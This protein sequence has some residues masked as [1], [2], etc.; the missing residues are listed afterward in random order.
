MSEAGP[1]GIIHIFNFKDDVTMNAGRISR[2]Q[3]LRLG[4]AALVVGA[5]SG[6]AGCGG[7][8]E[9]QDAPQLRFVN[10]TVDYSPADFWVDGLRGP[11]NVSSGGGF[12]GYGFVREGSRPVGVGPSGGAATVTVQ[13]SF[14]TGSFTTALALMGS[15]GNEELRFLDENHSAAP[16]GSVRL[17]VLNATSTNGYDVYVQSGAPSSSD[18]PLVAQGYNSLSDFTD[19]PSGW[20][21]VYITERNRPSVIFR[22]QEFNFPGRTV[23]SLVI[24]PVGASL[25]VVALQEQGVAARLTHHA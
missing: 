18:T 7:G 8:Q 5:G 23:G 4:T 17:R 1:C 20:R 10:A 12:T 6:L 14:A 19:L 21:R 24:V 25:A 13:R 3:A 22:S 16:A 15:G 9:G 2:R 11:T